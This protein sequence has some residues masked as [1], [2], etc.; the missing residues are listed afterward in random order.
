CE[1]PEPRVVSGS[2]H[3]QASLYGRPFFKFSLHDLEEVKST[4]DGDR[5]FVGRPDVE[6]VKSA[7]LLY[8][9]YMPR[10][11]APGVA[12]VEHAVLLPSDYPN[13]TVDK[14]FKA[15]RAE[16]AFLHSSWEDLPRYFHVVN[17]L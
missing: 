7:G 13:L 12:D 14:V 6:G 11:N 4:S 10:I 8:Y 3:Y 16:A 15:N 5:P 2:Y 1:L 9:K 17:A